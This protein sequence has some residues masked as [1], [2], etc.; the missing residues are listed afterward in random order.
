MANTEDR[1]L[2]VGRSFLRPESRTAPRESALYARRRQKV[3]SGQPRHGG[4]HFFQPSRPCET[5]Q[6][7]PEMTEEP[8]RTRAGR[9]LRIVLAC[10]ALAGSLA[11]GLAGYVGAAAAEAEPASGVVGGP[12]AAAPFPHRAAAAVAA[13]GDEVPGRACELLVGHGRDSTVDLT[14]D[15]LD[16][17]CR[18]APFAPVTKRRRCPCHSR[19]ALPRS[20]SATRILPDSWRIGVL[21][22]T[23]RPSRTTSLPGTVQTAG[24]A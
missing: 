9:Q 3:P 19:G 18:A 13:F 22:T 20:T 6:G 24:P 16:S 1:S 4:A 10:V 21:S 12:A 7:V 23:S 17:R 2:I 8:Q 5:L 11:L 14:P 15:V